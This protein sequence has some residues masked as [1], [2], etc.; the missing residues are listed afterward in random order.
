MGKRTS[1]ADMTPQKKQEVKSQAK[2]EV[3]LFIPKV[4][5]HLR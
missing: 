2:A 3:G 5:A 1:K 4:L